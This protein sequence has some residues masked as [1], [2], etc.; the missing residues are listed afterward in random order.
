MQ[1][2]NNV[3]HKSGQDVYFLVKGTTLMGLITFT[4]NNDVFAF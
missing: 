2:T 1:Q 4:W 3:S